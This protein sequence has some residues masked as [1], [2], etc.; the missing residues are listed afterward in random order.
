MVAPCLERV[1]SVYHFSPRQTEVSEPVN[2]LLVQLNA[3]G[4]GGAPGASARHPQH[5]GRVAP[6][7][8]AVGRPTPAHTSGL[9]H[10]RVTGSPVE[11]GSGRQ[12][13]VVHHPHGRYAAPLLHRLAA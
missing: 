1:S 6:G 7:G 8:R 4:Q 13:A 3:S 9:E 2:V 5:V 11:D 12:E 10:S